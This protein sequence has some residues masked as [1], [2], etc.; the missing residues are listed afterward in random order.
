MTIEEET[1]EYGDEYESEE[2]SKEEETQ[3]TERL[4][5][6]GLDLEKKGTKSTKI[7]LEQPQN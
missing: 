5:G 2:E 4:K 1:S 7:M 6:A 3:S